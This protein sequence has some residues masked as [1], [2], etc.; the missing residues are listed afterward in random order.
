MGTGQAR[1][2]LVEVESGA[3][4]V[5][6]LIVTASLMQHLVCVRACACVRVCLCACVRV[7]L[8]VCV[9]VF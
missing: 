1:L 6:V 5:G 8:F 3:E 2:Y 4:M 9:C 7:C